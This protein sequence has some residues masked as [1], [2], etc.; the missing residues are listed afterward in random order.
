MMAQERGRLRAGAHSA[1]ARSRRRIFITS[2]DAATTRRGR[3]VEASAPAAGAAPP[4][5]HQPFSRSSMGRLGG[6]PASGRPA[7]ARLGHPPTET[8]PLRR[9]LAIL[10][11]SLLGLSSLL[12]SVIGQQAQLPTV[13]VRGFLVSKEAASWLSE[14]REDERGAEGRA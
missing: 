11:M 2:A 9:S 12:E 5:Q 13:I 4:R 6:R 1:G 3:Q 14:Q 10:L 8:A 7:P